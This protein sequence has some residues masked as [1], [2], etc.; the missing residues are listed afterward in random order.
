MK[1]VYAR[2]K[3]VTIQAIKTS[4]VLDARK[5]DSELP[6]WLLSSI[7]KGDV[8]VDED[9]IYLRTLEGTMFSGLSDWII[10]GIAGEIYSCKFEIF[11]LTYDIVLSNCKQE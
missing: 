11:E 8:Q 3:P 1:V 9:G 5:N 6:T 10:C 4:D 7:H 2:K